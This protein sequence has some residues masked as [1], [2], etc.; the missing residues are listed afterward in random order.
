MTYW[1]RLKTCVD[2]ATFHL[3][4]VLGCY[5]NCGYDH[6]SKN[7]AYGLHTTPSWFPYSA[8]AWS[9]T[10]CDWSLCG[11]LDYLDV[12]YFQLDWIWILCADGL[13]NSWAV[14]WCFHC[15]SRHWQSYNFACFACMTSG[16]FG[17]K[18]D[19][20]GEFTSDVIAGLSLCRLD[21][22][23]VYFE[24]SA[25]GLHTIGSLFDCSTFYGFALLLICGTEI[26]WKY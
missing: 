17:A 25:A 18:G 4:H 13:G 9:I 8:K 16:H 6:L 19:T 11:E 20:K 14:S 2:L 23:Y 26:L 5:L 22:Q 7:I 1:N 10:D 3:L 12:C 21:M 24:N 15:F